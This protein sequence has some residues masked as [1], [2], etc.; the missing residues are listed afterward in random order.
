MPD[1]SDIVPVGARI[2][3]ILAWEGDK[4]VP[5]GEFPHCAMWTMIPFASQCD[6]RINLTME[7]DGESIVDQCSRE[8]GHP[9]PHVSHAKPGLP[10][11]AWVVEGPATDFLGQ[12]RA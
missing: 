8:E 11:L 7:V 1:L 5:M 10:V 3:Y 9:P 6:A 2:T 12:S 4:P